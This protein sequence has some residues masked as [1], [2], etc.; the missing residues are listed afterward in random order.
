MANKLKETSINWKEVKERPR[1]S[2]GW[3]SVAVLPVNHSGSGDS[4]ETDLKGD[5]NWRKSFGYSKAWYN[6]GEWYEAN[7]HG[8]R[9]NNITNLVTHWGNLPEVP[10]ITEPFEHSSGFKFNEKI[11]VEEVTKLSMD[12]WEEDQKT[13][14][15]S[16]NPTAYSYGFISALRFLGLIK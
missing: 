5:N 15:N 16:V 9:S 13:N 11:T 6:N 2:F 14:P 1:E 4:N 10:D 8:Y 12:R 7:M 3:Y